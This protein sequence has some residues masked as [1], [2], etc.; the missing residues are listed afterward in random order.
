[1]GEEAE[2]LRAVCGLRRVVGQR[3]RRVGL[4]LG[5]RG[6]AWRV[7]LFFEPG[8]LL[9][10]HCHDPPKRYCQFDLSL[11]TRLL[12]HTLSP[13]NENSGVLLIFLIFEKRYKYQ[14]NRR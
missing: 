1:M 6:L 9:V 5:D 7:Q 8:L 11:A 2:P 10:C 4:R 3:F 12:D 14:K 13:T